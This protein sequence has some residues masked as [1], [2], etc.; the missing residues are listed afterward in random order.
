M[1]K[2]LKEKYNQEFFYKLSE[3]LEEI[4]PKGDPE[5]SMALVFNAYANIIAFE[6]IE[7]EKQKS[8]EKGYDDAIKHEI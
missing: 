8:Y 3:K 4:Y 6:V 5:R 1:D 7:K 2:K